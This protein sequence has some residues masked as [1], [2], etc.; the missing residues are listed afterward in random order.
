MHHLHKTENMLHCIS[1]SVT[2]GLAVT[3]LFLRVGTRKLGDMMKEIEKR[4]PNILQNQMI[5]HLVPFSPCICRFIYLPWWY[6]SFEIGGSARTLTFVFAVI[7]VLF[8]RTG[9]ALLRNWWLLSV[10][11]TVQIEY[12]LQKTFIFRCSVAFYILS[13]YIIVIFARCCDQILLRLYFNY[14]EKET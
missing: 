14:C 13:C 2:L 12:A 6:K 11:G 1:L 10:P 4:I 3:F 5:T 9:V 8:H 7:G